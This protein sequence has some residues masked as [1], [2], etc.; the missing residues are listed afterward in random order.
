MKCAGRLD[1]RQQPAPAGVYL[2]R[3]EAAPYQGIGKLLL[4]K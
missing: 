2:V 3:L 1:L 4:L